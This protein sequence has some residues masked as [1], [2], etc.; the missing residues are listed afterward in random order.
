MSKL[1]RTGY[2]GFV[3]S[4]GLMRSPSPEVG[5]QDTTMASYFTGESFPRLEYV[6]GFDTSGLGF[7]Q[8]S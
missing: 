3:S 1:Y 2:G 4:L 7:S 8:D 5:T 6:C